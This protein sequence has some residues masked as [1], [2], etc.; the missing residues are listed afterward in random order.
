[1]NTTRLLLL[2]FF[3]L[4][5]SLA[6]SQNRYDVF[7]LGEHKD[8]IAL[9]TTLHWYISEPI[10]EM[11]QRFVPVD[12]RKDLVYI[13]DTNSCF[14]DVDSS[15][16]LKGFILVGTTDSLSTY[17]YRSYD[18][19]KSSILRVGDNRELYPQGF[20]SVSPYMSLMVTGKVT[21]NYWYQTVKHYKLKVGCYFADYADYNRYEKEN[22]KSFVQDINKLVRPVVDM[23]KI[24][25]TVV[26]LQ[27]YIDDDEYYDLVLQIKG[28]YFLLLSNDYDLGKKKLY[29]I[30][31]TWHDTRIMEF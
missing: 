1:M 25:Q 13:C 28:V 21:N 26:M 19:L 29:H 27:A 4:T 3:M 31:K 10:D 16:H 23:K 15:F 22:Y 20:R 8:S 9:D 30:E 24:A 17:A 2:V 6:F 7:F 12:I 11:T 18:N 5:Q 14:I